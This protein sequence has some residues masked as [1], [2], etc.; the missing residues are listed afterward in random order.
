MLVGK[1]SLRG[2]LSMKIVSSSSSDRFA[3]STGAFSALDNKRCGVLGASLA[4]GSRSF[5]LRANSSATR[6]RGALKDTG[7]LK[8]KASNRAVHSDT[9]SLRQ[10]Q[11]R[12][13]LARVPFAREVR[14]R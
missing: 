14:V 13:R 10:V 1:A 6:A 7:L 9:V 5:A 8:V 2:Q 3:D 12:S 4:K 11:L